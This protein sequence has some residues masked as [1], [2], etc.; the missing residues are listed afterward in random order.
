[1]GELCEGVLVWVEPT[2]TRNSEPSLCRSRISLY[3]RRSFV[4]QE[5]HMIGNTEE[6]MKVREDGEKW[7]QWKWLI[8][9]KIIIINFEFKVI[10]AWSD[11]IS[12]VHESSGAHCDCGNKFDRIFNTQPPHWN[13]CISI[14][15]WLNWLPSLSIHREETQNFFS[16]NLFNCTAGIE[17]IQS[18]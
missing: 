11:K 13:L 16:F 18:S 5:K 8:L 7:K 9:K 12:R 10:A 3:V 2:A 14:D 6:E 15:E 17:A 4:N 1:M